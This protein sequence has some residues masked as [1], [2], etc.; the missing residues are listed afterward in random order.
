[1]AKVYEYIPSAFKEGATAAILPNREEASVT[2]TSDGYSEKADGT[3]EL[4]GANETRYYYDNG[5]RKILIEDSATNLIPNSND[6]SSWVQPNLTMSASSDNIFL[7]KNSTRIVSSGD[8]NLAL[9]LG[10]I[11]T[12]NKD[13][14]VSVYIKNNKPQQQTLTVRK[15]SEPYR[16]TLTARMNSNR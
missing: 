2:R 13:I 14:V 9:V 4:K 1:M 6:F 8:F 11:D 15:N 10:G 16:Q 7:N 5:V 3:L 12:S